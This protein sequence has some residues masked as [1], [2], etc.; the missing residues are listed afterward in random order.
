MR[1]MRAGSNCADEPRTE[2]LTDGDD[3]E[4]SRRHLQDMLNEKRRQEKRFEAANRRSLCIRF[5]LLWA[6]S[7]ALVFLCW[8]FF[9]K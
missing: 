3:E 7:F 4:R 5:L 6:V 1:I 9:R 2:E 8:L